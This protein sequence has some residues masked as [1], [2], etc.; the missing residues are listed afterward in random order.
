VELSD[1][2]AGKLKKM[3]QNYAL[4]KIWTGKYSWL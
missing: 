3:S 2:V 4:N 1:I